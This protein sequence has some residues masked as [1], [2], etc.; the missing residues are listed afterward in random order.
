MLTRRSLRNAINAP[1]LRLAENRRFCCFFLKTSGR[2]WCACYAILEGKLSESKSLRRWSRHDGAS[3]VDPSKR[4]LPLGLC[5]RPPSRF[6]ES[7]G[8]DSESFHLRFK[9]LS[10][11][12]KGFGGALRARY[13]PRSLPQGV[14]DHCPLQASNIRTQSRTTWS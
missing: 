9:C 4:P 3:T 7:I 5:R 12:A 14:L 1:R 6:L 10:W 13:S 2:S 11:H 8:H